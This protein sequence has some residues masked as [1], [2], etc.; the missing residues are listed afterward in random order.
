MYVKRVKRALKMFFAFNVL[1]SSSTDQERFQPVTLT[2]NLFDT[3]FCIFY[4]VATY[5]N[6]DSTWILYWVDKAYL[7][8]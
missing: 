7:G 6:G 4:I 5:T 8:T 1:N 2:F 3:C